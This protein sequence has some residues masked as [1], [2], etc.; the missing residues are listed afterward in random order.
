MGYIFDTG[1]GKNLTVD[2]EGGAFALTGFFFHFF[3]EMFIDADVSH[4]ERDGELIE[5]TN[6]SSSPRTAA[7]AVNNCPHLATCHGKR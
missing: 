4:F 1:I 6:D 7:L 2:V 5:K 3:G